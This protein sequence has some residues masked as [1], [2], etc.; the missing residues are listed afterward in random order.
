M[1][2]VTQFHFFNVTVS[3]ESV[4]GSSPGAR[5]TWNTTVPPECVKSVRVEFRLS[6]H[7]GTLAIRYLYQPNHTLPCIK[8]L[9]DC[10]K[11]NNYP[12]TTDM[13]GELSLLV[14]LVLSS[15]MLVGGKN[16]SLSTGQKLLGS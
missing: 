11:A 13:A 12:L 8:A 3:A 14:A 4:G 10:D 15:C 2:A 5:V 9:A 6:S 7:D 1:H 16:C